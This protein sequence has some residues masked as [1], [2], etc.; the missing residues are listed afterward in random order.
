MR[1]RPPTAWRTGEKRSEGE[2][3]AV[4][5]YPRPLPSQRTDESGAATICTTSRAV[6]PAA[7]AVPVCFEAG[8]EDQAVVTVSR[9]SRSRLLPVCDRHAHVAVLEA[10]RYRWPLVIT[11]LQ[12]PAGRAG[13]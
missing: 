6:E 8:C 13:D 2:A 3:V 7:P 9:S 4:S 12:G 1:V 5:T 11:A 10:E